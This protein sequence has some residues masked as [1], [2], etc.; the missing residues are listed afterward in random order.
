MC[1]SGLYTKNNIETGENWEGIE[2][3]DYYLE[4][5]DGNDLNDLV[6]C[7]DFGELLHYNGSS[8]KSYQDIT[9][10]ALLLSIKIKDNLVVTA[11]IKN[12]RAFIA[13]GRR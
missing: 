1:G 2:V 9:S 5:I 3:S 7:G 10:G 6:I 11:G 4:S 12:P 8:W 13:I